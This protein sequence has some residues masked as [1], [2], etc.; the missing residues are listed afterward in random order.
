MFNLTDKKRLEKLLSDTIPLL[1]KNS[2]GCQLAM[3]VEALVGITIGDIASGSGHVFMVSFKQTISAEGSAK[4]YTWMEQSDPAE[5]HHSVADSASNEHLFPNRSDNTWNEQSGQD[6]EVDVK[7]EAGWPGYNTWSDNHNTIARLQGSNSRQI[8]RRMLPDSSAANRADTDVADVN[9]IIKIEDYCD[10]ETD[11]GKLAPDESANYSQEWDYEYDESQDMNVTE[12][13]NTEHGLNFGGKSLFRISGKA[14]SRPKAKWLNSGV[15]NAKVSAKY[16]T[17]LGAS[18]TSARA[19]GKKFGHPRPSA[20]ASTL[21]PQVCSL[22][23]QSYVYW[24]IMLSTDKRYNE[25]YNK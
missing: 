17:F 24:H 7:Y 20:T 21:Q 22:D 2:L 23:I 13:N 19:A 11:I 10:E 16:R 1:C 8:R 5:A 25:V 12:H 6:Q 18:S 15:K 14:A 9:N 3:N 4:S